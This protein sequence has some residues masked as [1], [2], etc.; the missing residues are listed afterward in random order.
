MTCQRVLVTGGT[1]LIGRYAVDELARMGA[2]VHVLSRSA[3]TETGSS[4]NIFHHRCDIFDQNETFAI[5]SAVSPSHLLHLAWET[6]H[7]HFWQ[8]RENLNWVAVTCNLVLAF[9]ASG[10]RRFVGAGTCAEYDWS[11]PD[12]KKSDCNELDSPLASPFLYGNS[13]AACFRLLESFSKNHGLDFAWGRVFLLFDPNEHEERLVASI[14][15]SLL[16]GK[17][18]ECSFGGQ[19][20]D[21]L[22]AREVGRAFAAIALSSVLGPV[23]IGSGEPRTIADLATSISHL[24]GRPDLLALGA[25]PDR[26][27]DP[28]RLTPNIWRL[29]HEVGFA[30]G[31]SLDTALARYYNVVLSRHL[32]P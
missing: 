4:E 9:K 24:V 17:T 21:F 26:D 18:A 19:L 30:A 7:G 13:K 1:G 15:S 11:S 16:N 27:F 32:E 3:V 22:P 14:F 29:R 25:L 10:G 12:L 28:V 5:M 20:R 2:E 31:D 6:R 23:N 8:A